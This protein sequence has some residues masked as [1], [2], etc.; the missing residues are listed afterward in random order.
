MPAN[1]PPQY[2]D[3]EQKLKTASGPEE[4]I[5]IYEELLAMIP[6]HKGTEKLQAMMK[7]KMA[8]L[9]NASQKKSGA[10]KQGP[11]H[12]VRKSG[13]GQIVLIGAPNAGKSLLVKTLTGAN[14]IVSEN[15]YSTHDPY[16]A[17]MPFENIK[18]QLVDT[19]P[20]TPE[21]M[22]E[23]YP[24]LIKSAHAVLVLLDLVAGNGV[25]NLEAIMEKLQS[26]KIGF[27]AYPMAEG[28]QPEPGWTYLKTLIAATKRDIFYD[29][30]LMEL[31]KEELGAE[32]SN[33]S[34]Y[35]IIPVSA[36]TG[37]GI[38]ELRRELFNMLEIIRVHSKIPG[39]KADMA[40]P[41]TLAAGSNVMDMAK[42]VHKDFA[43]NLKFARIWGKNTYEGQRVN[44]QHVLEDEDLLE[45]H[46]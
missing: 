45:L 29:P 10:V 38:E 31:V 4:K 36:E 7:T 35:N 32:S 43:E 39:K 22:E 5:A 25:E 14:P 19:P 21:F 18:I 30:E 42:A 40:E 6:K 8:K 1:L 34:P 17:M 3:V 27:M 13:A 12:K 24:D 28:L 2:K 46:M 15:A 33:K 44:R 41:F 16:P 26:K 11:V 23:W 9:K 20:I 37:E